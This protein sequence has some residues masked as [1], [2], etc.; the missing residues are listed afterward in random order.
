MKTLKQ[1]RMRDPPFD[2]D[3]GKRN[4][5]YDLRACTWNV[6]TLNGEGAAAQ[7]VDV[8][9]KIKADIT[10]VQ[11]MRWTGQ[12]QRRVGPC[13]IY[14]SGHTMAMGKQG[15]FGTTVGKFSLHDETSPNGLRLIDFAGARNMVICSTRFQHKKIHQATW[16]SPDRKT[17]NQID[18]VV[19]DGRHVP[20]VLDVRALR[21][22]NIDSDHY[23]VA[24]KI[25]TRL[26]AAKNARQQTQGR[27]DVEK[28][29]SQQTA[30]R[31]STR[32]ALLLSE[33]T[34]QQLGIGELWDGI[35]NSIRTAATETIGFR[36]E[37][38]NS[39]Y[40]EECRV[41]AE[42]KQAAYLATL[43]STTTRAG[44]D[45][46]RELKREARRICR[47]KKKEAEM[48]EYEKLDKLADRG[49]ARKFY[50]KKRRLTEGFKT[51]AYSCRTPKGDLV[52]DAQSIVKLWREHF[53]S[54][55]N[56]S[57]RTTPG[58][59]EPDSPIDDDGADVPLPDH[60]EV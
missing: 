56:G 17:T 50:E 26:C 54:L 35:S 24:A 20:S 48:R 47:Q 34:S 6:R 55:L 40:D 53:S 3:H 41:A 1:P 22:P 11:E 33:S 10:A 14:Y 21:G 23:L 7:L 44:W 32:L 45:R 59:G 15:I 5:N 46:Y 4:K 16:L 29:Q 49:N 19:I 30:E 25:R 38:K 37:Q 58:E 52:T 2:D 13:D 28:L 36:K 31:F 9:A 39:W 8:L 27:F 51:G 57:E 18:H 42:R 12:G 60:E 43:R